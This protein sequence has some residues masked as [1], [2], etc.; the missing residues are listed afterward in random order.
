M[1]VD[2]NK[3]NNDHWNESNCNSI[4]VELGILTP[5]SHQPPNNDDEEEKEEN[6]MNSKKEYLS[7]PYLNIEADDEQSIWYHFDLKW[8]DAMIENAKGSIEDAIPLYVEFI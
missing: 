2:R 1:G 4:N 5:G 3:N 6:K 7:N 8:L